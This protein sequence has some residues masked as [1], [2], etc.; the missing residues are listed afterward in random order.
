[1]IDWLEGR[2]MKFS[3]LGHWRRVTCYF[4]LIQVL[5]S[6]E[7]ILGKQ[8]PSKTERCWKFS[9]SS[10][11]STLDPFLTWF[12]AKEAHFLSHSLPLS[13]DF[14]SRAA[15]EA[16]CCGIGKQE[17][18]ALVGFIPPPPGQTVMWQWWWQYPSLKQLL[19]GGLSHVQVPQCSDKSSHLPHPHRP[20]GG[21]SLHYH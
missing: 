16:H 10:S 6:K 3:G 12:C 15:N 5:Y 20:D 11:I 13:S 18:R 8:Q 17:E 21:N 9:V 4:S 19:L 14:M 1:M 7:E 2:E